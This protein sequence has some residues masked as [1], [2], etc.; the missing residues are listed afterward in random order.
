MKSEQIRKHLD[1][2]AKPPGSLGRLEE[3]AFRLCEVQ[4]SLTPRT[5]P[6]RMVIFAADHGVVTEGVS[7]WNAE[8]TQLMVAAI[9]A[10][11]AASSVLAAASGTDLR[12]VDV[13]VAGPSLPQHPHYFSQKVR[14]GSRNLAIEP[15]L[16]VEEFRQAVAIGQEQASEAIRSGIVV[17]A[18]GEMGIGNSTVASCLTALLGPA[19]EE[20]VV[21]RG[22]GADEATLARKRAVVRCAVERARDLWRQNPESAIA[23]VGG[24]EVAAL[25]GFYASAA[26]AG[27]TIVLDGFIATAAALIAEQLWPG[28]ATRMIAAHQ[29]AE[30]G[31][32]LALQRLGLRPILDNWEL[33]LGEG[34]GALLLLPLLD[35]AAALVTRMA[36][37]DQLGIQSDAD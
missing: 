31:H 37:L 12:L 20:T 1:S 33:R 5:T 2:L 32:A 10:G 13:G 36:T 24:L 4:G 34:T 15:A 9:V 3:L 19:S 18:G 28:S 17:V 23:S 30:P 35:S 22:A 6:R 7:Q 21:G 27:M 29:S 25:A 11:K 16:T 26:A 14:L 8:V